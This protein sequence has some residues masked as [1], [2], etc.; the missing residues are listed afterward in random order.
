MYANILLLMD[1]SP[2]D[3]AILAHVTELAKVHRSNVHLFHVVHAHTLDQERILVAKTVEC[4][5]KVQSALESENIASSYSYA[6][7]EPAETVLEKMAA[8]DYDLVALATHGHTGISDIV[9]G[10]VSR[11]LKHHSEKPLLLLRGDM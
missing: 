7:G 8:G 4:L 3:N 1:C 9:L 11:E 5:S 2:V 10:S 6:E